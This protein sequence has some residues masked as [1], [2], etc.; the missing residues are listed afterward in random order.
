MKR[1]VTLLA[2]FTCILFAGNA[3]EY[4]FQLGNSKTEATVLENNL[5]SL[6]MHFTLQ[7]ISGK[8]FVSKDG[9]S[10][11]ELYFGN[12]YS[13]GEIGTPKLPAFRKLIQIPHGAEVNVKVIGYYE[14]DMK[15]ESLGVFN[16]LYPVQPS[17][18]KDQDIDKEPFHYDKNAYSKKGFQEIPLASVEVLGTLRGTRIARVEVAPVN[19]DPVSGTLKVYNDI[20]VEINFVGADKG[21][22]ETIRATT[23]SPYFDPI[24]NMLANPYTK[25]LYEDHPDLTNYPVKMLVVSH[26]M[27][28]ATLEPYIAWK[29]KKGFY[30]EVA[31]TDVIGTS[32]SA[33]QTFIHNK[34]NKATPENPAPT[35][36]VFVGDVQQVPA[37][38]T[39]SASQKMT[40]LYYAS[41]DGDYFPEMYYGRLSAQ[42][43]GQLE[44]IINKILY[45]EQYQFEDASY[46]NNA[47]LIAGTDGTWNPAV[48]QP[49]VKY[50]TANY[51]NSANGFN[52]VWGYGVAN[53]P[54]NPNNNSGYT[55]CYDNER[56]S[57]SFINFTAHCSETSWAGPNLTIPAV[58]SFTNANK[59][60]LAIG[61][62]CLA[63]DF[64]YLE[65]I[66]EAWIRAQNKG[67]VTYIGSSPSSYWF[68]DFY[69]AVG[70]FPIS[71]NNGGYVPTFEETTFGAYD[72]PFNSDYLT[73]GGIVFVGNLA[74]TEAKLQNYQTHSSPLY[75][76]QAYNVLGDPSVIHYLT[77]GETN[78]VSH[79]PILPIGLNTY[80]VTALPGSYVAISKDG[81]LH[82]AAFVD[83]T[84]DVELLLEPILDGGD[85][86]VVVTRPQTVPYMVQIPAAALEGPYVVLDNFV[87]NDNAANNNGLADY[88]ESFTVHVTI[89]NVG[90]D[91]GEEITASLTGTDPYFTV[92]SAG[93]VSFGNIPAGETGN[94]ATVS[95]AFAISLANNVPDQY[96]ATFVLEIT[97]GE[98]I[99]QSNF[100]LTANAPVLTI[101]GITID[102][103]GQGI[104]GI[105][106][107][108][109]TADAIIQVSNTGNADA[110]DVSAL[111]TT[112]SPYVTINGDASLNLGPLAIGASTSATF[113]ITADEETPLETSAILNLELES[114]EYSANKDL[115]IVI[116]YIPEYNMS[117][118]PVTACIGR[119]YDSG[120]PTGEYANNE[121]LTKTFFPA[122]DQATL[123]FNFTS[124]NTESGYDKLF[125]YDGVNTSAP[126]FPGS[127]F[128]GTV[129]PGTIMAT[130]EAGAITFRFTSDGSATRP[131]WEAEFYCVDLSVPPVCS[132]NPSPSVGQM[133]SVSPVTLSWNVVPGAL[134]YDVY[135]GIETLPAEPVA[136]VSTNS[137]SVSVLPYTLYV[138]KVVPKNNAG[139]AVGCS[140]WNFSTAD[141]ANNINMHTGTVTTCNAQFYDSGGPSGDYQNFENHTL[142][143]LPLYPTGKVKISFSAFELENNYDYLKIYNGLNASAPLLANLSGTTLPGTYVANNDEGALT[144]VFTSDVSVTKPGWVANLTCEIDAQ[145][146]TFI[147]TDTEGQPVEGARLAVAQEV[148]LT[149]EEGIAIVEL[150]S[151]ETYS[152]G[153]TKSGYLPATGEVVVEEEAVLVEV[154]LTPAFNVT[155]IVVNTQQTPLANATISLAGYGEQTTNQVGEATFTEVLIGEGMAYTVTH[156]DCHAHEGTLDVVNDHVHMDIVLVPLGTNISL[157]Q[158]LKVYPNPFSNFIKAQ[159]LEGVRRVE[160]TNV[161]GQRLLS[162]DLNGNDEV[163]IPTTNFSSGVYLLNFT[164]QNGERVVR[165]MIKN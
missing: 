129:S 86:N 61:N 4:Y 154:G 42:N 7:G 25:G 44:N 40:D 75:Y 144:F 163:H 64:G 139:E 46:L 134:Q 133:V 162:I 6:R 156:D 39:G 28:E 121:N 94:T 41:V 112:V 80:T 123:M 5:N 161:I 165:K 96:K 67:S 2:L 65:C 136:T 114:G 99:W 59:Y 107:P 23:Y 74:V 16:E 1:I 73:A 76:W 128:M 113:S 101:G 130:N 117:N 43:T 126:E 10:Y 26:R 160:I 106:D 159:G 17:I 108:G 153:I 147:V 91:P 79:L 89:K 11:T 68:D 20:E 97:D 55:G 131:G 120:G 140:I 98:D 88:G 105:L 103:D 115:T 102:D 58:N 13:I 18:R 95:N 60:P 87:I 8:D 50:A 9:Q 92:T 35:F 62:C 22:N 51:F 56:I 15:L 66:G 148:M 34:Y 52:T 138:W 63:A 33:I 143:V 149:N 82:G 164:T 84:G 57:V 150:P 93:P 109:E 36:L 81:V 157:S 19:Y 24:Y 27:F 21:L 152:W 53:D 125:I 85:V 71:G 54:N 14:E 151:N 142:T 146:V 77:E 70:A 127:P 158:N 29:T 100:R 37:S 69:W 110:L 111:L 141:I 47:T 124:F 49:T 38:A 83:E 119:F 116:G 104:P 48:G 3:Q 118:T 90:A 12:G 45:Y 32:A 135:L 155:F 145:E 72:A 122:N 31:Y 132:S 30:V 137:L 78:V